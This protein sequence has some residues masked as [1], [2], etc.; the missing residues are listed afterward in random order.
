RGK[1]SL[2][3]LFPLPGSGD[4][5]GPP[6]DAQAGEEEDQQD[7][8]RAMSHGDGAQG[9][10]TRRARYVVTPSVMIRSKAITVGTRTRRALR[11]GSWGRI[12]VVWVVASMPSAS[13][14]CLSQFTAF[15]SK[16]RFA[17]KL[18]RYMLSARFR[19]EKTTRR[20]VGSVASLGAG[21]SVTAIATL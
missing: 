3:Q 6:E 21:R 14:R 2:A 7:K 11:T 13:S 15:M 5:R 17:G 16:S 20:C 10:Q 1:Q 12:K 4:I 19:L 18:W 8:G 9:T